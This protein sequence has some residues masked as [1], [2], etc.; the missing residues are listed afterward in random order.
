MKWLLLFF[1]IILYILEGIHDFYVWQASDAQKKKATTAWHR[2][3]FINNALIAIVLAICYIQFLNLDLWW[4]LVY[5]LYCAFARALFLNSTF[6]LLRGNQI[7]YFSADY[8]FFFNRAPKIYYTLI[9][10]TCI[11]LLTTLIYFN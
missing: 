7:Y 2:Q 1:P 11:T 10:T 3:D 5:T 6:N 4:I 8:D 9:I